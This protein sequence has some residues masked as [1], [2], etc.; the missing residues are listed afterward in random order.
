MATDDTMSDASHESFSY[1]SPM[2]TVEDE[3]STS[4]NMVPRVMAITGNHDA[5]VNEQQHV[6]DEILRDF[7]LVHNSIV[8]HMRKAE[9]LRRLVQKGRIAA[10]IR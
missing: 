4:S 10:D 9:T 1:I 5:A 2:D 8:G 6:P 7:N 3:A